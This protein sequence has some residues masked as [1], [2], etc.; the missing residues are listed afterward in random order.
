MDYFIDW[1]CQLPVRI[2]GENFP[3]DTIRAME[4]LNE[5]YR[6]SHFCLMP[7]FDEREN[8]LALFQLR[9]ERAADLLREY[10]PQHLKIKIVP[11]VYLTPELW[12]EEALHRLLFTRNRY[13]PLQLPLSEYAEWMDTEI[14]RLLFTK[15][16]RLLFT[17][18]ELFREL[19][20][21]EIADK[22]FRVP[23]AAYQF[24]YRAL[25]ED[26]AVNDVSRL[27][28]EG[29]TVLLGTGLTTFGK[30]LQYDFAY[31]QETATKKLSVAD[32]QKLMHQ[33]RAFWALPMR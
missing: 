4:L 2:N 5:R 12:H 14:N 13:L 21:T 32:Y 11:R 8:S 18:C 7:E 6:I 9:L 33:N 26:P 3:K 22:L 10:L 20:P 19:Y 16:Y 23:Q 31:Y 17:S 15:K 24:N 29:K 30:T 1:N 25:T 27:L 28:A